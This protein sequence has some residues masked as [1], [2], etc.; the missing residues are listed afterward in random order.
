MRVRFVAP[1]MAG[2][3]ALA[4]LSP[5]AAARPDVG[6]Q[7][8]NILPP[9]QSGSIDAAE[10]AGVLAGD[11][12]GRVAVDGRNAPP[13]FAD[14]L[15][16]YDAANTVDPDSITEADLDT[17]YKRSA[18]EVAPADVVRVQRPRPGVTITWDR[19][20][21]PHVV[22]ATDADVA[23]GAGWAGTHDRMFLQDVLRHTGAARA[24]EFLGPSAENIAMDVEQLRTAHYTEREAA[25]QVA[26]VAARHGAEG[27]Q[28][29]R[30]IDAYLAG[31]NTAQRVL[32]PFG[33]H[34][35]ACP[36]EYTALGRVPTPWTRADLTYVASLVGGIF[37]KGGG[38]ETANATWFQQLQRRFGRPEARAVY[39][40]LRFADFPGAPTTAS[41]RFP[42]R[43]SGIDPDR[44]GVALPDRDP[45]ATAPGT[46]E[47]LDDAALP[48][49]IGPGPLRTPSAILDL[50]DR[51]G[52]SNAVL[53]SGERTPDGHPIAVFGPQ[54]G[55]FTPQLLTEIS[56]S[57]PG[58]RA[59]GVAFAGVSFLVQLG[60]SDRYAWSATSSGA[61]NVDT[62]AERLCDP[63]GAP[64]TVDAT[65]YLR[66]GQCVPMERFEHTETALPTIAAPGLP[67]RLRFLVLR[68]HHGIVQEGTTVDGEPV[69]LVSQRST[70]GREVDSVIGFARFNDP[71]FV[72]D[73][74]SFARAAAEIDYTFNWFYVDAADISFYSSGRLPLRAAG[75]EPDLPRW[76]D[77]EH[78]WQGWLADAAHPQQTN[79][80][81]G[82][83]VNWNNKPAPGFAAADDS[84]GLGPVHRSQPLDARVA[85]AATLS[86]LVAAVQDAA[87]V[88]TRAERVL[89]ALLAALGEPDDP[90]V[91]EA[92]ALLRGWDGHREDRD[93]DGAYTD[94]A[95]IAL[96]D[97]WWAGGAARDVLR[98]SLGDLVD[99]LPN[100]LDDHPDQGIGSAFLGVAW[101]GYVVE[102][103]SGGTWHRRYC[104]GGDAAACTAELR[105]SLAAAAQRALDEQGVGQLSA[106]SYDKSVD[107]I[108]PVTA[109]V[110]GTRPIDWQN[111]PTFQQVVLFR[112]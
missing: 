68:T 42:Y 1:I 112:S 28:L 102:D 91:A 60:R 37:G 78:D 25:D 69:A 29:L 41:Q 39:D 54:T 61:D 10:L 5:P 38:S 33:P 11:P 62:V 104:G 66:D 56:L 100:G 109:G 16:R 80:P 32:C 75:V 15:E 21:V 34:G 12:A 8:W 23:F 90:L 50:R 81:S 14:Q 93:R 59:R 7:V 26:A 31:I 95:A 24:A 17:Y 92:V 27:A 111:R 22:G 35:L 64:A 108:R 96:F 98:G 19:D 89:P 103:L 67:Q 65:H 74:A 51:P 73:A 43:G 2:G 76:G 9:G 13:N 71:G 70:Y 97:E 85:A 84:W 55:Y 18:F 88:D 79:P 106:L 49:P 101:Y 99:E 20:G 52:L 77:P 105:A 87:T 83:L 82:Q 57:G 45:A 58:I 72:T 63:S 86:E 47:R 30:E 94:Q 48:P 44:P 53:V 40:D 6:P 3:L 46:G 110:V 36:A 107:F 4:L